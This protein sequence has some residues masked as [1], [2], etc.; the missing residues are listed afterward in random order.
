MQ[1]RS[2]IDVNFK[3]LSY[4]KFGV[5]R[6][7]S[8]DPSQKPHSG[9]DLRPHQNG[10]SKNVFACEAGRVINNT[11]NKGSYI[12]VEHDNGWVTLYVHLTQRLPKIGSGVVKGQR[13][14]VYG[15][16]LHF[17]VRVGG[18]D[19]NP[20]DY[21]NFEPNKTA[22][23]TNEKIITAINNSSNF[24]ADTKRLLTAS[25]YNDDGAYL[26]AFAGNEPRGLLEIANNQ[27][28]N[29]KI[30]LEEAKKITEVRIV[31]NPTVNN[32]LTVQPVKSFV[33]RTESVKAFLG[34]AKNTILPFV[35]TILIGSGVS[36]D[37]VASIIGG[38]V[39]LIGA[40]L[41]E[42]D[43][44]NYNKEEKKNAKN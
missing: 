29:L 37:Q 28:Y 2:P 31:E 20:E 44:T 7:P 14:G 34:M 19:R 43:K 17:T 22:E 35:G 36:S 41:L 39:A 5:V 12:A 9:V 6:P 13:I 18:V 8:I 26:I 10:G 23:M 1:L 24:D 15:S 4:D 30:Q 32:S 42:L 21:I 16:H 3:L 27:I 11:P 40:I 25:V 38:L 33:P